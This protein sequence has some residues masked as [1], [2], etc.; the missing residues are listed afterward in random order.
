MQL[1]KLVRS[2]GLISLLV[3]P[4]YSL[5]KNRDT[6]SQDV[7]QAL[8]IGGVVGL[9]VG[10]ILAAADSVGKWLS[11]SSATLIQDAEKALNQKSEYEP[12][13]YKIR[14]AYGI[15]NSWL[16]DS[17][18]IENQM[19]E[20]VLYEIAH[21]LWNKGIDT[22][23]FFV[24][25]K[26]MLSNLS[27]HKERIGKR[28]NDLSGQRHDHSVQKELDYMRPL[29]GS[30]QEWYVELKAVY[31]YCDHH[32]SFFELAQQ[33]WTIYKNYTYEM[34]AFEQFQ[35]DTYRLPQEM[36]AI[37]LSKYSTSSYPSIEY[38][39]KLNLD[40]KTIKY[41]RT[42]AAYNYVER[43]K[44]S[45]HAIARLEQ[46]RIMIDSWYRKEL[47]NRDQ[48]LS[49]NKKPKKWKTAKPHH[50]CMVYKSPSDHGYSDEP[51]D[52]NV[53]IQL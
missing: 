20:V 26:H 13:L 15:T 40:L 30:F 29:F 45:D 21:D 51:L 5:P 12:L 27:Y 34:K 47:Y 8:T 37:V 4:S 44:W 18:W 43:F 31:S 7:V 46:L 33:E 19:N 10:G 11:P 52:I 49:R 24:R 41:I 36:T 22:N 39:E 14:Q 3:A 25:F 1:H 6:S 38:T 2:I 53:Q 23:T 32:R 16:A 17:S 50:Y 35:Y 9:C 48:D 28:I 42:N